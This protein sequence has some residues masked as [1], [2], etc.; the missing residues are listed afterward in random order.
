MKVIFI[1]RDIEGKIIK[2]NRENI[3]IDFGKKIMN[4]MNYF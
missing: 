3:Y 4:L 2:K 1:F